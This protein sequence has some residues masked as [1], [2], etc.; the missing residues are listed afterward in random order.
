MIYGQPVT[1]GGKPKLQTKTVTPSASSKSVT[2]DSGY[3]GLSKVTVSG[4]SNLKAAN[5]AKGKSI[6][7]VAGSYVGAPVLLW[8][9]LTS[10]SGFEPQ[11]VSVSGAD[12]GAY[13]VEV[14]RNSG[15]NVLTDAPRG[16]GLIVKNANHT[17]SVG[18]ITGAQTNTTSCSGWTRSVVTATDTGIEFGS[19]YA[20]AGS[21]S[22]T[23]AVPTRIWGVKFSMELI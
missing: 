5:I 1:F 14:R 8:S 17:Q 4:D 10:T 18:V 2:P 19:G 13:L 7:G 11:T 9:N 15:T 21:V 16:I 12:Y 6:F 3:D 20:A 23:A 22:N